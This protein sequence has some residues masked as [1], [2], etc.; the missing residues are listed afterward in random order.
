[1][2]Q[3]T[4]H[5]D[6]DIAHS[7]VLIAHWPTFATQSAITGLMHHS[8]VGKIPPR[9]Y[10]VGQ[11]ALQATWILP[12]KIPAEEARQKTV[13]AAIPATAAQPQISYSFAPARLDCQNAKR[14]SALAEAQS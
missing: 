13:K 6:S 1:L 12:S 8:K 7:W 14:A 11:L 9:V 5:L 4:G 10:A 2:I 3:E